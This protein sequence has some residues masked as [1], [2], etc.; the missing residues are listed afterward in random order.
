[1]TQV[2]VFFTYCG[3]DQALKDKAYGAVLPLKDKLAKEGID[4][5]LIAMDKD[6]VDKWDIW[7]QDNALGCDIMVPIIT[8]H[9]FEI[10]NGREKVI[11]TEIKLGTEHF[12]RLVPMVLCALQGETASR[13][14]KISQIYT[15][16]DSFD[17]ALARLAR[18]VEL[19]AIEEAEKKR[20]LESLSPFTKVYDNN[21]FVGRDCDLEWMKNAF[22]N[23]NVLVLTG[24]GGIGKT[25]LAERFFIANAREYS[26][27]FIVKAPLFL[28]Y[29]I[30]RWILQIYE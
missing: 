15:E 30:N 14:E 6:C 22:I 9:A 21:R 16:R 10:V 1:V 28:N 4:L 7:S 18:S 5:E 27:A 17:D 24:E 25:T 13:L 12:K 3:A 23:S 2:R 20:E 8:E 26:G 11:L 29:S 19:L